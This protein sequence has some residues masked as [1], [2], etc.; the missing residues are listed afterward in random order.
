M[1]WKAKRLSVVLHKIRS[2]NDLE[3]TGDYQQACM[4][5][6]LFLSKVILL[7]QPSLTYGHI[8]EPG[9]E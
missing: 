3:E 6:Y 2:C 4:Q 7:L 1:L 8:A 5:N 9:N